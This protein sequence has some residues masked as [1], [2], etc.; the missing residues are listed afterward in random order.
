MKRAGENFCGAGRRWW[1]SRIVCGASLLPPT[2]SGWER[3]IYFKYLLWSTVYIL[4]ILFLVFYIVLY[5]VYIVSLYRCSHTTC[6]CVCEYLFSFQDIL[7][8]NQFGAK[9]RQYK[10]LS[11]RN[12]MVI[13][14]WWFNVSSSA[15]EN[16][17]TPFSAGCDTF[18]FITQLLNIPQQSC[19][20]KMGIQSLQASL[21]KHK[22]YHF[23]KW[24]AIF[25]N[26]ITY[27]Q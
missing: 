19:R 16:F 12:K 13:W 18:R 17:L 8:G 14:G 3:N 21:A 7:V 22:K 6:V 1:W 5:I 2:W 27:W 15:K 4:N 10:S 9:W 23:S 25:F 26:I 24:E 20:N 11:T